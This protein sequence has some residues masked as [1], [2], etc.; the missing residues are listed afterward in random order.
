MFEDVLKKQITEE[1]FGGLPS[2]LPFPEEEKTLTN[3]SKRTE[4]GKTLLWCGQR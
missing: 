2:Y 3:G 4:R 1:L